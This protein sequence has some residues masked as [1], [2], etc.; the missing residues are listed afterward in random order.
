ML[1]IFRPAISCFILLFFLT[2]YSVEAQ[3][4]VKVIADS[5]A[6]I[7]M[8]N[9]A[10]VGL[11]IGIIHKG[12]SYQFYYGSVDRNSKQVPGA[13]HVF[14]IGSVSKTFAGTLLAKAIL[15]DKI[16]LDGDVRA[17]MNEEYPTLVYK[18]HPILVRH[19]VTHMSGLPG[20]LPDQTE[21]FRHAPD[22]I[23]FIL[24]KAFAHNS[25]EQ[26]LRDLHGVKLDTIPG[27][28]Y[29]YSNPNAQ[30]VAILLENVYGLSYDELVKKFITGPAGM[31]H[32]YTERSS[33][34][35]KPVKGYSGSGKEM[36]YV[37]A[38]FAGA[39]GIYSTP[40]DMLRYLQFQLDSTNV[41]ARKAR[42]LV[43]GDTKKY[44]MGLFWRMTPA[45]NGET[46]TWHTGGTFG[47]SSY[48]VLYPD[49]Q[50]GI[51]LL[52][53]EMD[54]DSQGKLIEMADRIFEGLV[55]S[56]GKR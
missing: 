53:N 44:A 49:S 34:L 1:T 51:I 24:S 36:P 42:Q 55:S 50:T 14:E 31:K 52:S 9:P 13:Q 7:F 22:S 12:K 40:E 25:R 28:N 2:G 48:C 19:L 30:L 41:I 54:K 8:Q 35:F 37:P 29:R 6:Q 27:E 46:K 47:F 5:A 3:S 11:T 15:D 21:A 23:P 4:P 43:W 33:K 26:F 17:F 39:G 38:A 32:T 56:S 10:R 18:E 16:S 45:K 20:F